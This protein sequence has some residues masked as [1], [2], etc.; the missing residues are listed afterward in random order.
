[1][2]ARDPDWLTDEA[3]EERWRPAQWTGWKQLRRRFEN[4]RAELRYT[5]TDAGV[6]GS[7]PYQPDI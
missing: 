3:A 1:M 6:D 5:D 4:L 7:N 2:T